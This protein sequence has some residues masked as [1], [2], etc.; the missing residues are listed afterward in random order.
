MEK[1][2]W[3][4]DIVTFKY[5]SSVLMLETLFLTLGEGVKVLKLLSLSLSGVVKLK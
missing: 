4:R 5:V 2:F 3:R 1:V